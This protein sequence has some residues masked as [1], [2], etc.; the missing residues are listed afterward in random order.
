M[1]SSRERLDGEAVVRG[2]QARPQRPPV[3]AAEDVVMRGRGGRRPVRRASPSSAAAE[4]RPPIAP[5]GTSPSVPP[6]V[7]QPS[8][9]AAPVRF[10]PATVMVPWETIV[11]LAVCY[12]PLQIC[13]GLDRAI[14]LSDQVRRAFSV[15]RGFTAAPLQLAACLAFECRSMRHCGVVP[16]GD[17]LA[18]L[19]ALYAVV[20]GE[21]R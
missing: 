4:S 19:S 11:A 15:R 10:A 5:P 18:Y 12:D 14:A 8:S 21:A 16:Q 7:A 1:R 9:P 20:E 2:R 3:P 6:P 13:G 17:D